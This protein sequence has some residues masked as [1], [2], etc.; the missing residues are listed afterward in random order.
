MNTPR[1]NTDEDRRRQV[2]LHALQIVVEPPRP[3]MTGIHSSPIST[4]TG[5]RHAADPHQL[6]LR[7]PSGWSFW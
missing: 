5:G 1:K 4:M 6:V 3:W 7:T 2:A